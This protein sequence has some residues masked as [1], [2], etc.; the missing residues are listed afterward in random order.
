VAVVWFVWHR[1]RQIR[2]EEAERHPASHEEAS[3]PRVS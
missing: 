2:T 1:V 3:E